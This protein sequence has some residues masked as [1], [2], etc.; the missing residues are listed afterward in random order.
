MTTTDEQKKEEQLQAKKF[1]TILST[2][3]KKVGEKDNANLALAGKDIFKAVN[4][5]EYRDTGIISLNYVLNG[6]WY[7]GRVYEVYGPYSSGKT[8]LCLHTIAYRQSKGEYCAF[9]DVEHTF[10]AKYAQAIGIDLEKLAYIKPETAEQAMK[11]VEYLARSGTCSLIVVDSVAQL[12]PKNEAEKDMEKESIGIQARFVSKALKKINPLLQKPGT[13]LLLINQI[14]NKIEATYTA[15]TT[16]GGHLLHF[17][18]TGR[19]RVKRSEWLTKNGVTYAQRCEVKA[20]KHKMGP[21]QRVGNFDILFGKGVD[22]ITDLVNTLLDDEFTGV[23]KAGAWIKIDGE[24]ICQG[25][26]NL[27]DEI[28]ASPR[29]ERMLRERIETIRITPEDDLP[30]LKFPEITFG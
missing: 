21:P 8:T 26:D 7:K 11:A 27:I 1:K 10:D 20:Q 2:I 6:G 14:R 16:P 12:V 18:C 24:T 5:G 13:T 29:A 30:N 19:I 17:M 3:N 25:K 15:E 9:V 22:M 28:K 4:Q 23:E